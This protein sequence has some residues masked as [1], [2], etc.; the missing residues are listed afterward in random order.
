MRGQR[1]KSHCLSAFEKRNAKKGKRAKMSGNGLKMEI[2]QC[3]KIALLKKHVTL[4]CFQ[5]FQRIFN[6]NA[7][8]WQCD[9][10]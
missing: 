3:D 5:G 10:V 2:E 7:L 9:K 6:K 1:A 4:A 8:A